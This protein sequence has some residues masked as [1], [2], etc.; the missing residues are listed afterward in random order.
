[1]KN[2]LVFLFVVAVMVMSLG[3]RFAVAE[4]TI[5]QVKGA[6]EPFLNQYC[7]GCHNA[8]EQSGQ[9]RFD[10][11][12]WQIETNDAAQRWQDVLDQ[13]TSGDMP[14]PGE[15]KPADQEL[16]IVLDSLTKVMIDARRRLTDR[17]GEITLRRLNQREYSNTIRH[18]F[19]FDVPLGNIPEDGEINTFDTVGAEQLYT[20]AHFERYLEL[21]KQIAS[22][23]FQHS[24][25]P[26][27]RPKA[28]RYQPEE[29]VTAKMREKLADL[30]RKMVLRQQGATWQEMGFKDEGEMQ[31][32]FRQWD[33]RAEKPRLYL[34]YPHTDTGVY[35]CD[36][37]KWVSTARHVDLRGEYVIRVRGGIQGQPNP[38][39]RIIRVT[40]PESILG[41]M[42][43]AGTPEKP[44]VVEMRV[45]SPLGQKH[46]SVRIRENMPDHTINNMH[47]YL[48]QL[49]GS[50][51]RVDPR[52]A[53]WIDWIEIDGPYYPE[54]RSVWET[55]LFPNSETSRSS[56][57]LEDERK[58]RE[59]LEKFVYEAFRR[60]RPS[61][62]FIDSLHQMYLDHLQDGLSQRDALV[63]VMGLVLASPG[64]LFLHEPLDTEIDGSLLKN[65][66]FA[67]RLSYFLWSSPPDEQLY[68]ADLADPVELATHVDRMLADPKLKRFRDGFV[69]QWAE[70]DRYDAISV[71]NR[72][73]FTFNE[74]V[75]QDAKKEVIEFFGQLMKENLSASFLIDSD[76]LML[77][78]A[79]A[80]HYGIHVNN[81]MTDEFQKVSLPPDSP[82]GGLM[83]QAAFLTMGSNGERSS[84]VIRGALVM[85][86][87][88]HDKPAPPPPNVPELG[89]ATNQP[90]TNREMVELHQAQVVCRSCHG[91]MDVIGFGLENF[92]SVGRWRDSELVGKRRVSI[93]PEGRLSN[94][95]G[96][97]TVRDL[98]AVLLTQQEQVARELVVSILTYALGR[99][100][101][102]SDANEVDRILENV[103][104]EGYGVRSIIREVAL[105]T[106]LRRRG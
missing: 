79:M 12:D 4:T 104:S 56:P 10:Q 99:T 75:M 46:L 70:F 36:V 6:V 7:V 65:R 8:Q 60:N 64:F 43:L 92:D 83:T 87:L 71:D 18:L 88:L 40:G 69:S 100:I 49:E 78:P 102:F 50:A 61:V 97:Q 44:E 81:P 22:E 63:E 48:N 82:R 52:A 74:G 35:I 57:Y 19:G 41:T 31:I 2:R 11:L 93:S 95:M 1:M 3:I 54:Q 32:I 28:E 33:A 26:P 105:S 38:L 62:S 72:K 23:S 77:N 89:V 94:G 96:F 85:E 53:V 58:V 67:N 20:S 34:Q 45:Q 14:P 5:S 51:D 59:L 80:K 91:K 29:R 98:K 73:H 66:E 103:Q 55:I 37:A 76:F 47:G 30:D 106:L 84:P 68:E 25:S 9:R 21:G 15:V 27:Q 16:A 39:R 86:K 42:E 101:E 24:L 17:G 13:L 90:L